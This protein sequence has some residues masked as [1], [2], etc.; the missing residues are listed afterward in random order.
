VFEGLQSLLDKSLIVQS[1][2]PP[3]EAR[4]VMLET[5]RE[6]AREHLEVR[7]E[8]Q[9]L[10]AAHAA[11]YLGLAEQAE[12][13]LQG[14]QIGRWLG[15]LRVERD[16][17]R[18]ALQWLTLQGDATTA[19]RLAGALGE[20]WRKG[21]PT[22]DEGRTWLAMVLGMDAPSPPAVRA[23]ALL[24]A[25]ALAMHRGDQ[26]AAPALLEEAQGL[27]RLA[28]DTPLMLTALNELGWIGLFRADYERANAY[29]EEELALSR[30]AGDDTRAWMT[31]HNLGWSHFKAG[32][33]PEAIAVLEQSLARARE[34][35]SKMELAESLIA[36]GW[37]LINHGDADRARLLLEENRTLR[38]EMNDADGMANAPMY[39]GFAVLEQGQ[40]AE[41]DALLRASLI[42]L[43]QQGNVVFSVGCVEHLA[44]VAIA[45]GDV[46]RATLL[47]GA[48]AACR[49]AIPLVMSPATR[50]HW[51]ARTVADLQARLGPA[52][53]AAAWQAG[54]RMSMDQAVAYVLGR[55]ES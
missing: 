32:R 2:E 13:H 51:Y 31:L 38:I 12:P 15:R 49:A 18:A 36:L 6:Y 50:R 47:L 30:E 26:R 3:G 8:V 42:A 7:G 37:A 9:P 23:K 54:E 14:D 46:E 28:A 16:N 22:P 43:Q 39:L 10:A 44:R 34:S 35:G 17:L 5:I 45:R 19:M 29:F 24:W 21:G 48:M 20:F 52:A 40:I 53:F 11:W 4:F 25:G 1:E 55:P 41:A 33:Y 27:A